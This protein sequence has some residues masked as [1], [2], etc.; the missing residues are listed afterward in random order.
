MKTTT[1]ALKV[2]R[3]AVLFLAFIA[4]PFIGRAQWVPVSPGFAS[5]ISTFISA[6]AISGNQL[7]TTNSTVTSLQNLTI[8]YN[9]VTDITGIQ[10]FDSLKNLIVNSS[11]IN[12]PALPPAL[13]TFEVADAGS[14]INTAL[15]TNLQALKIHG[16]TLSALPAF[17]T[18]LLRLV[19][20]NLHSLSVVPVLPNSLLHIEVKHMN[21]FSNFPAIP[22]NVK[23]I[24]F[25]YTDYTSTTAFGSSLDTLK[26]NYCSALNSLLPLPSS[27]TYL[28]LDGSGLLS[29]SGLPTNMS[30][31]SLN[32]CSQLTSIVLPDTIDIL[33]MDSLSSLQPLTY[34]NRI[35]I[36][37]VFHADNCPNADIESLLG[38]IHNTETDLLGVAPGQIFLS[39]KNCNI[40]TLPQFHVKVYR[41]SLSNNPIT[42][43]P[44]QGYT[45]SL[46]CPYMCQ[47]PFQYLEILDVSYCQLSDINEAFFSYDSTILVPF[48]L[49]AP[50]IYAS[51][52]NIT[53]I[54]YIPKSTIVDYSN[55]H[56]TNVTTSIKCRRLNLDSNLITCLPYLE[57][58][59]ESLSVNANPINCL[60]NL[61]DTGFIC[62]PNL[63]VCQNGNTNNCQVLALT[64]GH[65]FNDANQNGIQNS[66]EGPLVDFN[67]L[68]QPD[69]S[70]HLSDHNGYY[71]FNCLG[72]INY[73]INGICPYPYRYVTT[74]PVTVNY[75]QSGQVDTIHDIGIFIEPDV[76]DML[77]RLIA[78]DA[79]RPGFGHQ[80][81]VTARN[82]GTTVQN[83]N[84]VM[85]FDAG[86]IYQSSTP[87]GTVSG[88]SISWPL[89]ALA[90]LNSFNADVYFY[91]S[92]A[93]ALGDTVRAGLYALCNTPDTTL[94]DN[95]DTL[96][97][98]AVGSYD[99][100][101]KEVWPADGL[102][103]EQI[104]EGTYLDYTV[105]FQNTGTAS[106]INV[107]VDD[108]LSTL[109][110]L[111]SFEILAASHNYHWRIES[112]VLTVY[113]D[114]INLPD[115]NSNER[116][117][118]GFFRY[119]IKP[120]TSIS[121]GQQ[122]LNTANIYFDFNPAVVT[123]TTVTNVGFHTSSA[124]P[125]NG[126]GNV[127][128]LYPNPAT[129]QVI[130]YTGGQLNG[131]TITLYSVAGQK[132]F[133][134]VL[135]GATTQ[136]INTGNFSRGVYF[137]N[138]TA[139]NGESYKAKLVLQ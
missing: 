113:F 53:N 86:H 30:M 134:G 106:A 68:L 55:N 58:A 116:L 35:Y 77:V 62:T 121:A 40:H 44:T 59:V 75:T 92:A 11:L 85:Y 127:F 6:A 5:Y 81:H 73:T 27:V 105:R 128:M 16:G 45:D 96:Q 48:T 57:G 60:P 112:R 74:G 98:I 3:F 95:H 24:D 46:I 17:P 80:Y 2:R 99:P 32:N 65:I 50:D 135:T 97:R 37:R 12:I 122:I 67:A 54:N 136:T 9:T 34:L 120:V 69:N 36:L 56:A 76:D 47:F 103:P 104:Q 129:S 82:E 100:N 33:Y 110:D 10:Y 138:V 70:I 23:Y 139:A 51:H 63:G 114:N 84:V 118:H 78:V 18:T 94:A 124:I 66:G 126:G 7:D 38:K 31:L 8:N 130:I 25:S 28:E 125:N 13:R 133:T 26:L 22:P 90:P 83:G 111:S 79:A 64:G 93:V 109:L 61:P 132:V 137:V 71:N 87:T 88:N 14:S 89:T 29:L 117:S 107:H 41:L 1:S 102:T 108:T 19:L 20:E 42:F 123:N 39:A 91:V 101:E 119:R 21:V 72:G 115:S 131:A 15:P 43:L 4:A 49:P 52:N